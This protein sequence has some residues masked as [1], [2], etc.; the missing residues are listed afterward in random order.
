M[1]GYKVADWKDN[2]YAVYKRTTSQLKHSLKVREWKIIFSE[3]GNKKKIAM[4]IL[5]PYKV[6]FKTK[7][8]RGII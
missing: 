5:I 3:N 1:K 8:K 2:L 6:D 7:D 4:A